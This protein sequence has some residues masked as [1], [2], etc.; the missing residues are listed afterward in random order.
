MKKMLL[1]I[2]FMIGR[3]A[4]FGQAPINL[5]DYLDEELTT[6]SVEKSDCGIFKICAHDSN[7][8][9]VTRLVSFRP[10]QVLPIGKE[11][12]RP[13]VSVIT[14]PFKIR[15]AVDTFPQNVQTGIT[16]AGLVINVYNNKLTR[17]FSSGKSS[18]HNFGV[19]I[20]LAPTAEE[21]TPENSQGA[22]TQKTKQLFLSAGLSLTYSYG[23]VSLAIIP[24]GFDFATTAQGKKFAHN[25]QPWWGLG[26]GIS[27]KLFGL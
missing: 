22:V 26:I 7:G 23:D 10:D 1:V 9:Y 6:I 5:S 17:Y 19:G 24:I 15:P 12:W 18:I 2:S 4:V 20:L 13:T 8:N 14:I 25:M 21:L 11:S 3:F 27:T 16:N